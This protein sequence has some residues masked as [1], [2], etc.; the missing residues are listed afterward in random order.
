MKIHESVM[1][2]LGLVDANSDSYPVLKQLYGREKQTIDLEFTTLAVSNGVGVKS[3]TLATGGGIRENDI[4]DLLVSSPASTHLTKLAK[5]SGHEDSVWHKHIAS[6]DKLAS[7]NFDALSYHHTGHSIHIGNLH[8]IAKSESSET[9][10][11]TLLAILAAHSSTADI[12]FN[13]PKKTS[14][15]IIRGIMQAEAA[16]QTYPYTNVGIDGTGQ[17]VGIGTSFI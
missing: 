3:K 16:V 11:A 7:C 10:F 14:N 4:K 15:Y 17:V 9:C 2:V 13:T 8:E 1:F 5:A 12:R 6:T